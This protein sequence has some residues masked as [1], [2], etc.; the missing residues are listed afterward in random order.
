MT[1][2]PFSSILVLIY[3]MDKFLQPFNA[4]QNAM[5][6]SIF[7]PMDYFFGSVL[8]TPQCTSQSIYTPPL[9][10]WLTPH[11]EDNPSVHEHQ[12][13]RPLKSIARI[14][15]PAPGMLPSIAVLD[16]IRN[17]PGRIRELPFVAALLVRIVKA[18]EKHWQYRIL[19]L[20]VSSLPIY[21]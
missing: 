20:I 12:R 5:L 10:L 15:S 8:A 21:L 6:K 4:V 2:T 19:A 7:S 14:K 9:S 3:L 16:Q 13:L 11:R 18:A 1:Y 17:E